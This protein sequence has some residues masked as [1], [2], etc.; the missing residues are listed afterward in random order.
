[1]KRLL[2]RL[3][4]VADWDRL[5]WSAYRAARGKCHSREVRTFLA[6]CDEELKRLQLEILNGTIEVGKGIQF[7]I[8]DPKPRLIHAPCFRERVLHHAL[9]DC[10]G[11]TLERSLISDTFACRTGKGPLAAVYRAQAHS[12]RLPW[13]AKMDVRGYF[14]SINHAILLRRLQ[15]RFKGHGVLQLVERVVSAHHDSPGHGLPIGALTSQWFGNDYLDPLD[16]FLLESRQAAGFVRYM[17][18]FVLWGQTRA[19][20]GANA[21]AAG[22]F[23]HQQ[24]DLKAKPPQINRSGHGVTFCGFRVLPHRL[25]LSQRRRKRYLRRKQ[26]WEAAFCEGRISALE[27]QKAYA[28]VHAMTERAAAVPFRKRALAALGK[29]WY[30]EI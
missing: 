23:L 12:R 4:E 15:R 5:A 11:P 9:M 17:D 28:S 21:R 22:E 30:E 13:Y 24:L 27:L 25:R 6:R 29:A 10:L 20:V 16:R 8:Y 3:E 18:D 2:V 7:R 26:F 14:A 1:M 19:E